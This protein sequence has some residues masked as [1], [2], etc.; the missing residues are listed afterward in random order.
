M[1]WT[2]SIPS[3]RQPF[4][5]TWKVSP[6]SRYARGCRSYLAA[7]SAR[8]QWHSPHRR[9]RSNTDRSR[10]SISLHLRCVLRWDG[11]IAGLL[12]ASF[13]AQ[14]IGDPLVDALVREFSSDRNRC[15]QLW[16]QSQAE[17]AGVGFLRLAIQFGAG[18]EIVIDGFLEGGAQFLNGLAMKAHHI[19][20]A[21]DVSH[22]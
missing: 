12:C 16:L 18:I 2:G 15:V 21:C 13:P 19:T 3:R 8:C 11:F 7:L 4:A 1:C 14:H 17:L 10:M 22:E 20:N 5:P 6:R 9:K